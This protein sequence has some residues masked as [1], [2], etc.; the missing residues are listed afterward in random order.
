MQRLLGNTALFHD[1]PA[2]YF[3]TVESQAQLVHVHKTAPLLH[4]GESAPFAWF[5]I[6]GSASLH[7]SRES[8][9]T[10]HVTSDDP[11]AGYPL[12]HLRPARYTLV[13]DTG[14][15]LIRLEL[16]SVRQRVSKPSAPRFLG[17][18]EIGGGSWQ[19][20]A[21]AIEVTRQR[22]AAS[23]ELPAMPAVS[24]RIG[25]AL[26]DPDFAMSDL[27]R[28]ISADPVIAAELL[29]VANSALF[30]GVDVCETLQ[31]AIV[32]LGLA[33]TQTL[34]L[35][36]ATK[37]MFNVRTP[38][39]KQRLQRMWRHAV[40]IGAYMT[41]L[42]KLVPQLDP[43]KSLLAGLL[44]EIGAVS[45]LSLAEKFPQ[46]EQTPGVLDAVLANVVPEFSAE[47]LESWG[48]ADFASGTIHQ[49]N[50]LYEHDGDADYADLLIVAHLHALMKARRFDALPRL[51][52]MPA[53]AQ[54]SAHGLKAAKS[55]EVLQTAQ[56]ELNELR[57]LL[58]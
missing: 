36:L 42:G 25:Q 17:G 47:I 41:V 16:A 34:V 10:L 29:K 56:E 49:E 39:I 40:E 58:G 5:L 11:A 26:K 23:L 31:A 9:H 50:W 44:H 24:A 2:Q 51:T 14:A 7:Q 21:F 45:V 18:D 4:E 54:L 30:R 46:L 15:Q 13:P 32:R 52:E 48:L 27:A 43:S 19:S 57:A 6:D 28:L 55:V 35:S 8:G 38:W 20:H 37:A 53:Y 12:A 3:K 33:Q 22:Q 1:A